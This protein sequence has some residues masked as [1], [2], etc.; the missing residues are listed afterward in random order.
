MESSASSV[1][2]LV[3][4]LKRF[5]RRLLII[6]ENRFELLIVEVQEERERLLRAI[7]LALGVAAFAL[8]AATALTATIAVLLW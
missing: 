4:T 6:G 1:E 5:A 3:E 7:L 8:L 2:Q